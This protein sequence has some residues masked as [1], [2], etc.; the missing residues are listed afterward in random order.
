MLPLYAQTFLAQAEE[1]LIYLLKMHCRNIWNFPTNVFFQFFFCS[2]VIALNFALLALDFDTPVSWA[3][4]FS[5]FLGVCSS[6]ARIWS[7][8]SSVSTWR[9][10]FV[11]V[12]IKN[13]VVLN[14]FT[15]LWIVCLLGTLSPRKFTS[16][17]S[18]TLTS[19]SV[20]HVGVIQ[21]YAFL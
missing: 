15:K 18:R 1:I 10:C 13:P 16:K 12:S 8:F 11:F 6:L 3:R 9:L 17:F 4:R 21:K 19:R 14:L 5:D 2:R 20:F 7:N